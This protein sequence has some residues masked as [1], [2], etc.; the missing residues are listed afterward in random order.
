M[1]TLSA[2]VPQPPQGIK[3]M[4]GAEEWMPKEKQ[5][6][7]RMI[8]EEWGNLGP[9]ELSAEIPKNKAGFRVRVTTIPAPDGALGFTDVG[10]VYYW[11]DE[12]SYGRT[13]EER[14]KG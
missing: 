11:T 10:G 1:K 8:C 2:I 13:V 6:P 5:T 12:D 14:A 9:M 4:L 3:Y 7:R